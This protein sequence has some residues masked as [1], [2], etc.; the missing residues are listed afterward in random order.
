MAV[1]ERHSWPGNVRHLRNVI[2]SAVILASDQ[3]AELTPEHL[4]AEI[5]QGSGAFAHNGLSPEV[6]IKVGT[7]LRD[8]EREL[9]LATLAQT[10]GN[11]AKA[12]RLLGVGRKTLYRKLEEYGVQNDRR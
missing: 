1:L 6:R 3:D 12:A 4:P 2:E 11:R 5:R 10:D 7:A 8:A 9:I